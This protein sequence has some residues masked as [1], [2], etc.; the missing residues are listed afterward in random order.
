VQDAELALADAITLVEGCPRIDHEPLERIVHHRAVGLRAVAEGHHQRVEVCFEP[1][2][3]AAL[4]DVECDPACQ[5]APHVGL[6]HRPEHPLARKTDRS[7][8][9]FSKEVEAGAEG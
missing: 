9:R 8:A 3:L 5:H 6:Q 1:H 4:V 7:P 2:R